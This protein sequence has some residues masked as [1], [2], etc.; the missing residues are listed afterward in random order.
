MTDPAGAGK[1]KANMTGF[2]LDGIH[3]T[4]YQ[5]QPDP[6]WESWLFVKPLNPGLSVTGT[7]RT[8]ILRKLDGLIIPNGY[9]KGWQWNDNNHH[10]WTGDELF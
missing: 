1:K 5:H 6:S 8:P 4:A 7:G 9:M 3:G 10:F 2:F